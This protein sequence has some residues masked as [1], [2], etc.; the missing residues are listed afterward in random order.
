V[1]TNATGRHFD[2]IQVTNEMP[3]HRMGGV[4]TVMESLMSGLRAQ[5]LR[6]LWFVTDHAYRPAQVAGLLARFPDVAVGPAEA[7]AAFEAPLLHV[8]SYQ[9]NPALHEQLRRRGAVYTVHSLLAFEES[10]NGVALGDAVRGQEAMIALARCVVLLSEA[11]RAKYRALGYEAL[12]PR[13]RVIHNGVRCAG[14]YRAPRARRV[15]GYCGRLVP[16][17]HPEYVQLMLTEP[18]FEARQVLIAGRG[19]SPYARDLL[20]RHG[21]AGRVR[22]LGWCA[23]ARLEAFF[24]AI[25]VLALPSIYEPFGLV[26]LEAAAR[27]IPVVCPRTDGL[28]EA[29]GEHAFYCEDTSYEAFR[30]AMRRWDAAPP[31]V[32]ARLCDGARARYRAHFTDLAMGQRYG[33]LYAELT[34]P[35]ASRPPDSGSRNPAPRRRG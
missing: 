1:L 30:A 18:G 4:G 8:H 21:L 31:E 33:A 35:A 28:V 11:E 3:A 32:L 12:N 16:R 24:D 27:G 23:G 17:K 7:L 13:V 2:I 14:G 6:P 5:G 22:F 15:L 10:S 26:A 25:D 29:L 20:A 19:F 9:Q 34:A